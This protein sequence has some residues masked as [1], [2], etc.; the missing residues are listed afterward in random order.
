MLF[1]NPKEGI[2]NTSRDP[3]VISLGRM[4]RE[5]KDLMGK[6]DYGLQAERVR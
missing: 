4:R 5:E 2:K 3:K 1:Q 6:L